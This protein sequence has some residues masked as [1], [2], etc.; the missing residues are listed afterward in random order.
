MFLHKI[1]KMYE[2]LYTNLPFPERY[3]YIL[4]SIYPNMIL[5]KMTVCPLNLSIWF[6]QSQTKMIYLLSIYNFVVQIFMMLLSLIIMFDIL[7]HRRYV[8][9]TICQTLSYVNKLNWTNVHYCLCR[10]NLVCKL[11]L[12]AYLHSQL[13]CLCQ[14]VYFVSD[15]KIFY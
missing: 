5:L 6:N 4:I 8:T 10:N 7:R 15:L 3:Y 9:F 13:G 12:Y 14:H 2:V 1:A 11:P